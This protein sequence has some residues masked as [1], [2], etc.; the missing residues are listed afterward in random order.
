MKRAEGIMTPLPSKWLTY[1]EQCTKCLHCLFL[2]GI[3]RLLLQKKIR[4]IRSIL[5]YT[6]WSLL[7]A[8]TMIWSTE[9]NSLKLMEVALHSKCE[10][11]IA[12]TANTHSLLAQKEARK[13][14]VRN[15]TALA[16]P[17]SLKN[18]HWESAWCVV[19]MLELYSCFLKEFAW[20][21]KK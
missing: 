3:F 18:V 5:S 9:C 11:I 15:V 7:N 8:T 1:R 14:T 17:E 10:C 21:M 19:C 4:S 6:K 2:T 20:V 12:C 16:S 13:A